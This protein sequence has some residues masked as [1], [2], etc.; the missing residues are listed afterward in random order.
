MQV[1][2][3]IYMCLTVMLPQFVRVCVFVSIPTAVYLRARGSDC[4]G[5]GFEFTICNAQLILSACISRESEG[6]LNPAFVAA[7]S[8]HIR[9]TQCFGRS[10][11]L[12]WF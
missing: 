6:P 7:S 12:K 9:D 2:A 3:R 11:V 10:A 4:W 1:S 8:V 5:V